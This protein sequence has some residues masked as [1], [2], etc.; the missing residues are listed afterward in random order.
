[1]S[2]TQKSIGELPP[3]RYLVCMVI[4]GCS[5]YVIESVYRGVKD[6]L[7]RR[8]VHVLSWNHTFTFAFLI[9]TIHE[10][11]NGKMV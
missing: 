10:L 11:L 1:M 9:A 4:T 2:P 6:N 8:F 5:L 3:D 7:I